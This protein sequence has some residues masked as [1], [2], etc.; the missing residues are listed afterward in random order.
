MDSLVHVTGWEEDADQNNKR[1]TEQTIVINTIY[2]LHI[3]Y[4]NSAIWYL[5]LLSLL[6]FP[7]FLHIS[8]DKQASQSVFVQYVQ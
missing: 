3:L 2:G 7:S 5:M 6:H 4:V 8:F 1:N